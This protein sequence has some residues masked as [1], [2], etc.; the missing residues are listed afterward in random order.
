MTQSV[1]QIGCG[2]MGG[3]LLARWQELPDL[4][5]SVVDPALDDAPTGATLV[6]DLSDLAPRSFDLVI[7]AIKPQ[8]IDTIIPTIASALNPEGLVISI[9]AGTSAQVVS[10]AFGKAPVVRLMPNMPARVGRGVSGLFA[11]T[12]VSEAQRDLSA[13]LASA[14]GRAVWVDDEDAIDRITASVGSGPGYIFE[15]A[16]S[17]QA[18]I[19]ALGFAPTDARQMVIE[20]MLGS[21]LL[22]EDD[23]TSFEDLRK[24][25]TSKGGTTAAGLSALNGDGALDDRLVSALEAAYARAVELRQ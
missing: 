7:V 14:A 22:A 15:F 1:L 5:F 23:S 9:A 16:R 11:Q 20:T 8:L 2:N 4:S 3:A 21:L 13:R 6:R 12:E 18:S 24:S 17:Y 10:Q 25:I 19:E